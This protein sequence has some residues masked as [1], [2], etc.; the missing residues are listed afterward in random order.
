MKENNDA[1]SFWN[2][3]GGLNS[4]RYTS[5]SCRIPNHPVKTANPGMDQILRHSKSHH[6]STN[7]KSA[8]GV[9]RLDEVKRVSSK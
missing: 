9:V 7:S 4:K 5:L 3:C 1:T 2:T 8:K 6:D